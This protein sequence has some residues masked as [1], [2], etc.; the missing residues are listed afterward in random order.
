MSARPELDV[1]SRLDIVEI[2]VETLKENGQE[3]VYQ[4][5]KRFDAIEETLTSMQK[6]LDLLV[7]LRGLKK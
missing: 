5:H 6:S 1:E 4:V 7:A 3:L 2:Q